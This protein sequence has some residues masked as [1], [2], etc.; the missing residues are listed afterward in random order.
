MKN[1]NNEK[2]TAKSLRR[3]AIKKKLEII[4]T[5]PSWDG[6]FIY[7]FLLFS[8]NNSP[9]YIVHYWYVG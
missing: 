1:N 9:T 4:Q 8:I 7:S 3:E 2:E 5:K 6:W